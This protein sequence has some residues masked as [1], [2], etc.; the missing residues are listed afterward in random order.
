MSTIS[1][2][3]FILGHP[4][5]KDHKLKAFLR[6]INWQIR[7]RLNPKQVVHTFTEKSKLFIERGMTGATG[8]LY[9]G[10]HEFNDMGFLL[11]F[12]RTDDLFVDVGANVGSYTILASAHSGANSISFEPLPA[13]FQKLKNN[14]QLNQL[15]GKVKAH[16]MALGS[17]AGELLFT[18]S[19]DT[20]NHVVKD[21]QEGVISVQVNTL[22]DILNNGP[23]PLLIKI[24]VEGFETEVIKGATKTLHEP[25]LKA[26]IIELNGSGA[27]YDY[28]EQE[29]HQSLLNVGFSPYTYD[30]FSRKLTSV[31]LFGSLNTIY[32][33][34]FDFVQDRLK[35]AE[36]VKI[37]KQEF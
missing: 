17:Q 23:V 34:D 9:C 37:L 1:N 19:L 21:A 15:S 35:N 8:N 30:P 11:H 33:R 28:D 5:N 36:K 25:G 20:M 6:F 22:D 14:I 2:I 27:R 16:N 7:S 29:I 13:T 4:L 31:D 24:D 18:N 12:L 10:L 32:I 3:K 26:I